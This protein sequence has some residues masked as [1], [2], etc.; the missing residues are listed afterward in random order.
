MKKVLDFLEEWAWLIIGCI[1]MTLVFGTILVE[2]FQTLQ[3]LQ[4]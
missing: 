2:A 4:P 3:P 1:I